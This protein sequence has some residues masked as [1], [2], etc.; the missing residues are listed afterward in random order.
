MVVNETEY[1]GA[2][3]HPYAQLNFA[4]MM[5]VEIKRG[6]PKDE[7]PGK[8]IIIPERPEQIVCSEVSL[9]KLRE[10]YIKHACSSLG[11][12]KKLSEVDV[13]FLAEDSRL[14]KEKVL[15]L[16]EKNGVRVE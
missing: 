9:E 1:T 6:N 11:E 14:E 15:K 4:K 8:N 3:K 5:G 2:G 13:E 10:S 12:E 7:L 16:L